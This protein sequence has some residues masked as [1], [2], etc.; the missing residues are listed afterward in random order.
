VTS[1]PY[2]GV[3]DYVKDDDDIEGNDGLGNDTVVADEKGDDTIL[4]F[5]HLITSAA[6]T[7]LSLAEIGPR[8]ASKSTDSFQAKWQEDTVAWMGAVGA[9]LKPNG[10]MAI[11]I[12]D[13]ADI[14]VLE[15]VRS[16]TVL[17]SERRGFLLE[18]VASASVREEDAKRRPW[19]NHK[20][21]YRTEHTILVEKKYKIDHNHH[22]EMTT[23]RAGDE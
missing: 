5:S 10:R 3:Y 23:T 7:D 1:P 17:A 4:S 11:L 9:R 12:G 15:S 22:S 13:N 20:R 18:V 16:A 14:D 21:N 2:P 19:G 8:S 6:S